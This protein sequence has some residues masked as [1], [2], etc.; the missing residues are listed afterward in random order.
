M[1]VDLKQ[2]YAV[3]CIAKNREKDN[4]ENGCDPDT[5]RSWS[6]NVNI[7]ADSLTKCLKAA[8][9]H[10]GYEVQTLNDNCWIGEQSGH[11]D[12]IEFNTVEDGE[13][14]PTTLS[15]DNPDGFACRYTLFIEKRTV[16]GLPESELAEFKPWRMISED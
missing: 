3:V 2:V 13:G 4:W 1:P 15:A 7:T 16:S 8:M 6:Q 9:Y 12:W 14:S 11:I 5:S 10:L